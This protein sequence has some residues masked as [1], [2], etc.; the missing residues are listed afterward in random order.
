MSKTKADKD[1][2]ANFSMAQ[3]C[4]FVPIDTVKEAIEESQIKTRD[5]GKLPL[6]Q[7]VYF[8]MGM[9][10]YPNK[11]YQTIYANIQCQEK[12]ESPTVMNIPVSSSF[13]ESRQRLGAKAMEITFKNTVGPIAVKRRTKGAFFKN[14]LITAIDGMTLNVP[15]SEENAQY[16]TRSKSQYG[17]GA[18]PYVRVLALVECGTRVAFDAEI[19]T[20]EIYSEQG[21][22]NILLART[23]GNCLLIGDRLYCTGEKFRIATQNGAKVI[24]RA[25]SDTNLPVETRLADDSFLSNIAEGERRR[26]ATLHP[27]RV[28]E[29]RIKLGGKKQLVRLITNLTAKEATPKEILDL[30]RQRWEWETMA[31]EFKTTLAEFRG[32]LKSKTADLVVQEIYGILL[33]HFSIKCFM[34][35]AALLV[36]EDMDQLSFKHSLEVVKRRAPQVGAFPP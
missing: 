26:N 24:F 20:D 10:L 15:D 22:A 17:I 29:F 7:M 3:L 36:N 35:E 9:A 25:K 13:T 34:H 32:T 1:S 14:W 23:P 5:G 31:K 16:F 11:S 19:A 18:Y 2:Q 30:Y 21:L 27:V 28:C 33:T 6:D 12:S 8:V 4:Q